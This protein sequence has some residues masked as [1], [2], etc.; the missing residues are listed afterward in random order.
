VDINTFKKLKVL[1]EKEIQFTEKN[2]L[3]I[4]ERV[5]NFFQKYL[6]IYT[7]ELRTLKM[8]EVDREKKYGELYKHFKHKDQYEWTQKAEIESQ[9]NADPSYY[10]LRMQ[11]VQQEY[12]VKYLE[13]VLDNIKRLSYSIKNW[14]E[15]RK[16]QAGMY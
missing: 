12:I 9:M 7:E 11:I 4:S 5:P 13:Q 1:A 6:D 16:F 8:L 14:I 10:E 15:I 3:E 2:A